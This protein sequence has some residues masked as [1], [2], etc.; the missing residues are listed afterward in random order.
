MP[1]FVF[2][3][4]KMFFIDES[5]F[6]KCVKKDSYVEKSLPSMSDFIDQISVKYQIEI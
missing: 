6:M 4:S 3:L 1:I 2:L 5:F